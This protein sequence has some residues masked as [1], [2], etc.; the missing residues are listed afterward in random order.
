MM[1]FSSLKKLKAFF[2]KQNK[3]QEEIKNQT[4][5]LEWAHIYHD[6]IRGKDFLEKLP[7]NI[8]RWAGNYAFFYILNRILTEY[9]P[10]KI[11]EFGLGES[12]KMISSYVKNEL[13]DTKHLVIEQNQD[14]L[15]HFKTRFTLAENTEVRIHPQK[16]IKQEG[17]EINV[18][19]N[20]DQY[21]KNKYDLYV[22]DGPIGSESNSRID[23]LE[24]V[25]NADSSDQFIIILD[26]CH[27]PG[28]YQT[29]VEIG[30]T[31]TNKGIEY[32]SNTFRG[33]KIVGVIATE[34]YKWIT[35]I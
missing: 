28:E 10:L 11:I 17:S 15:N 8:G 7:L 3:I 33:N 22:I 23:I 35:S 1:S 6:S 34:K 30:N 19:T 18:Y 21:Y 32:A 12:S 29:L 4:L 13:I 2:Y 9:K 27:R 25:K 26:D 20:L 16:T 31:L 14:W 5:E 24:F